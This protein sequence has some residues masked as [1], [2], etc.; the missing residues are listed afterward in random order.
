MLS[1]AARQCLEEL[2]GKVGPNSYIICT[3]KYVA[4]ILLSAIINKEL[5][6]STFIFIRFV[7]PANFS[8]DSN[9]DDSSE[10]M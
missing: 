3:T 1:V 8:L 2:P 6:V 5:F 9:P 10:T 4:A 7:G